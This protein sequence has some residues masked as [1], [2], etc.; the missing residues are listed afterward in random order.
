M[1]HKM[2]PAPTRVFISYSHDSAEHMSAVLALANRLRKEGV[3]CWTDQHLRSP[4]E[5]WP[6]WCE[7]QIETAKFVLVACTQTY[8]RRFQGKEEPGKGKGV[9]FEGFIITQELYNAQGKNEKF[10]PIVFDAKER[11]YIPILLQ[12][13]SNYDVS[14]GEGYDDLYWGITDQFIPPPDVGKIRYRPRIATLGASLPK[15]ESHRD[16]TARLSNVPLA[17]NPFFTGRE[18]TLEEVHKKLSSSKRVALSGMRGVGKTRAAVEYVHR[19]RDDYQAILWAR[20]ETRETLVGDF[21]SV[22]RLLKLPEK[23]EK[24]QSVIVSAV[25]S[26]LEANDRWLLVFDNAD[27]LT[28]VPDFV[29]LVHPG[30]LLLTTTAQALGRVAEKVLVEKM[31]DDEGALLLLRRATVIGKQAALDE[32][33]AVDRKLAWEL[34]RELGGLPLALDQAGAFIEETP[35]TVAE[36]RKLYEKEGKRLRKERGEVHSEHPSVTVTFSLAFGEL[37]K[38]DPAAADLVRLCAFL[39]PDAIPE[40]LFTKGAFALGEEFARRA[41]NPLDFTETLKQAAKFSLIQRDAPDRSLDIHRLVQ[42][43]LKDEMD[44]EQ[45]RE[46]AERAVRAVDCAFPSPEFRSW[47]ECERLLPHAKICAALIE[48]VSF[49]F[50]EAARLLNKTAFYMDD[51]AQYGEAESLYQRSLAIWE[52]ALG[53][54]HPDVAASLNNLAVLYKNQGRYAEAEPLYQRS[55]AIWEKTLGSEHLKIA[56]SLNNLAVLYKDQGRYAEAEPL[57]Q[58]SQAIREKAL[59]PEDPALATSLNNV[60]LFYDNQGR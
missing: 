41:E 48:K 51:R 15:L 58:R 49:E 56:S 45:L 14:K 59:G 5:G 46:W 34:A 27:D 52:K 2:S 1:P 12:G 26:W 31:A 35:S 10:I 18:N 23:D 32:A 24:D 42:A 6:R 9:T 17:P 28:L 36:Y 22:A 25:K 44:T 13:A 3:D 50:E 37:A 30:H 55:L 60:A 8:L 11:E 53:P 33:T 4:S 16:F 57:Y 54:E 19:H 21:A 29:P 38:R 20:A 7:N 43:V 47:P 40:E 39:A